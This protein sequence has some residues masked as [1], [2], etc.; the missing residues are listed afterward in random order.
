MDM[1]L[2]YDCVVVNCLFVAIAVPERSMFFSNTE[3]MTKKIDNRP[4]K[5]RLLKA[6]Q[7]E[8]YSSPWQ[9]LKEL[10]SYSFM[11]SFSDWT[12]NQYIFGFFVLRIALTV[13]NFG[14]E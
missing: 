2:G 8:M 11:I 6:T 4:T 5:S 10:L 7:F 3:E 14:S 13:I 9:P 1:L 12:T